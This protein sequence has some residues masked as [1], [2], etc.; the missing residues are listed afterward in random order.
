MKQL[1]HRN[2]E[3]LLQRN[4]KHLGYMKGKIF[5]A[6]PEKARSDASAYTYIIT[7]FVYSLRKSKAGVCDHWN[8]TLARNGMNMSAISIH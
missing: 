6:S 4:F 7:N 2:S 1:L 5:C 3:L 8:F